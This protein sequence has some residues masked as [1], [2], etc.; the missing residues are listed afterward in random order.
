MP[1]SG[2]HIWTFVDCSVANCIACTGY[3]DCQECDT[4]YTLQSERM[5]KSKWQIPLALFCIL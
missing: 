1:N 4:G 5:C 3:K 2:W